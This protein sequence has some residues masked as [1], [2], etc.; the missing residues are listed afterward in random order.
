M[1]NRT[2]EKQ[3][4]T[5]ETD[6]KLR[7]SLD[8]SGEIN[9]STGVG[10]FDH[11]LTLMAKHSLFD[12]TIEA[13]G[14]IDVDAHHTVEDIGLLL[15]TALVEALGDK[16]GIVRYGFSVVPMDETRVEVALDLS[17]RPYLAWD[18]EIDAPTVGEFDTCLGQE[19]FQA[20]AN[21]G[22]MNLHIT[23]GRGTNPHH[24]LEAAFKATGRALRQAV[25][26]DDR[27]TGIPSSK[28]VL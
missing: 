24:I 19:F 14:D 9:V 1:A 6:I 17:G 21:T 18:C 2:C 23:K 22:L 13:K 27:E 3:R 20:L 11:M 12:L 16:A 28:G 10:F 5:K 8:G 4:T 26:K 25:G 15:G 7:L